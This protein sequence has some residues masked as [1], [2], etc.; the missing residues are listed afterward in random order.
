[1]SKKFNPSSELAAVILE[2]Y[3]SGVSGNKLAK[4]FNVGRCALYNFLHDNNVNNLLPTESKRLYFGHNR[5]LKIK[6]SV[7]M[8]YYVYLHKD[9]NGVIFYV[10]KGRGDRYKTKTNRSLSWNEKVKNGYSYEFYSEN[11]DEATALLVEADLIRSL[12]GLI[13]NIPTGNLPFTQEYYLEHFKVDDTSPSGIVRINTG[14]DNSKPSFG[15]IHNCQGRKYW[16]IKFKSRTVLL[17][18]LIWILT[19][20]DIPNGCVIDHIDG[21][22]LNNK[23]ENLRSVTT[24][25]NNK[26]KAISRNNSSGVTGVYLGKGHYKVVIRINGQVKRTK[27]FS[28]LDDPLNAFTLA[29]EWRKE[30]IALLNLAGA[31]YTERHGV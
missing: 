9:N 23:L 29:C 20:G 25:I 12:K 26:N 6:Q 27:Y 31:G 30:Q 18:R 10:G 19:N 4:E 24:S 7:C 28:T 15:F 21:D 3:K 14:S 5:K 17:H 22:G 1:M 16:R 11:L 2:K 8:D 13:N